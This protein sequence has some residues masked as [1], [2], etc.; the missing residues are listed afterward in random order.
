MDW[1]IPGETAEQRA[2]RE[3]RTLAVDRVVVSKGHL[4]D[5]RD[6]YRLML[7]WWALHRLEQ[8]ADTTWARVAENLALYFGSVEKLARAADE[9]IKADRD[10]NIILHWHGGN[11]S[12]DL[13]LTR[14]FL[15]LSLLRFEPAHLPDSL[16]ER[17]FLRH[18][19]REVDEMLGAVATNE[20]L[21]GWLS[22]PSDLTERVEA[23]RGLLRGNPARGP[24]LSAD[25][26]E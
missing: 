11:I 20:E 7:A 14:T 16:G 22:R 21:W 5:Y 6:A 3:A 4:D 10:E 9:A 26:E 18:M 2:D 17:G 19:R 13:A 24:K 1:G 15:I 23:L 12:A 8:T 25:G